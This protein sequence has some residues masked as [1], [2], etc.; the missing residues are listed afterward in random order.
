MHR[1]IF[2]RFCIT[3]Y[4]RISALRSIYKNTN[5]IYDNM[6]YEVLMRICSKYLREF[7]LIVF[8]RIYAKKYLRDLRAS[9]LRSIYE[10]YENLRYN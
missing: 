10:I 4:L 3:K 7:A 5:N 1:E 8:T 9:A 6:H 2:T